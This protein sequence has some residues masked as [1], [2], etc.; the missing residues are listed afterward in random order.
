VAA[1]T[2]LSGL[3]SPSE[4]R[5]LAQAMVEDVLQLLHSHVLIE[6][7]TL[8]SDDPGA[9]LLASRYQLQAI[10]ESSLGCTGLNNVLE[11]ACARM[12]VTGTEQVLVLHGDLPLLAAE[13][14][15]Q[16][17]H[18]QA[19]CGALVIGCD[20]RAVGTNMLAFDQSCKPEFQFGTD[21]CALHRQT[22]AGQ[23]QARVLQLPG[24][25]LDIDEPEDLELLLARL[26]A[27]SGGYTRNLLLGSGL[28]RRLATM[29]DMEYTNSSIASEIQEN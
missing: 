10:E 1:K 7:I 28:G 21:S 11:A 23:G 4:R 14:I 8:V 16:V 6:D 5:A 12:N 13:E 27:Q 20:R 3:L 29:R 25:G 24:I 19:E 2:R 22:R 9:H 18:L 15:T 17:L 26:P